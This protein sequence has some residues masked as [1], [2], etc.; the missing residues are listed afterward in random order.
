MDEEVIPFIRSRQV[1]N[2]VIGFAFF[3]LGPVGVAVGLTTAYL[4]N[5]D[6]PDWDASL[7]V[8][9]VLAGFLVL[10]LGAVCAWLVHDS[11]RALRS[12]GIVLHANGFDVRG[13]SW[14]WADL[15][16]VG[17]VERDAEDG[18]SYLVVDLRPEPTTDAKTVR[19]SIDPEDFDTAGRPLDEI[20]REWMHRH[21]AQNNVN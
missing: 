18:G 11:A 7:I 6:P 16:S 8:L 21:H 10:G 17:L 20:L 3:L 4:S 19:L 5:P 12:P 15:E 14:A 13:R 1:G 9:S 2:L